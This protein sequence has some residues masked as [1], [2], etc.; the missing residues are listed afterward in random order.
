MIKLFHTFKNKLL[1]R[2]RL[3]IFQES[4]S[5]KQPVEPYIYPWQYDQKN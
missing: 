2:T 1:S 5:A 4:S 3:K